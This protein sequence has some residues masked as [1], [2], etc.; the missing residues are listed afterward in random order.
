MAVAAVRSFY[1]YIYY[2]RT[3]SFR[4]LS[5]VLSAFPEI[6]I[7]QFFMRLALRIKELSACSLK[8]E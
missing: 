3:D 2:T 4:L 6:L 7:I 8:A 1:R 5:F